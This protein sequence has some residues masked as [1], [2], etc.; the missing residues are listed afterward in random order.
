M[1]ISGE[2]MTLDALMTGAAQE[3]IDERERH[4]AIFT[5]G[6]NG[7]VCKNEPAADESKALFKGTYRECQAWIERRGIAAALRFVMKHRREVLELNARGMTP[8][9]VLALISELQE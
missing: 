5:E 1:Q 2:F 9:E 3:C 8:G 4:L 6:L 7:Y